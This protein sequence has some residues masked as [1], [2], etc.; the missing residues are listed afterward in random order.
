MREEWDFTERKFLRS[1]KTPHA[2]QAYLDTLIYNPSDSCLSPRYVMMTGEGH[3]LEGGLFAAAA[4]EFHGHRPL[5]VDLVA[6]LD[7]HH[8]ITVYKTK[9]GWGSLSK[10]NT[11]LLGGRLPFYRNIRELVMSYFDFYF[12]VAG[13]PS[14]QS[15]SR[16]INLNQLNH[17]NWRT[18]DLDLMN[19]GINFCEFPHV[20]ITPIHDLRKLPFVSDRVKDAC[21]LGADPSGL[22][23]L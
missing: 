2:I 4:L 15:Y 22:Y 9:T 14:L 10:S 19:M 13:K 17:W 12:N 6:H 1:L 7:D 8:V 20:E 23:Q 3:C 16:P 11:A 5:M 18:T 21:F